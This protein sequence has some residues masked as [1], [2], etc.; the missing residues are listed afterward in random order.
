MKEFLVKSGKFWEAG[1][2]GRRGML[3]GHQAAATGAGATNVKVVTT[4]QPKPRTPG[5]QYGPTRAQSP[6]GR[7]IT[8]RTA[9]PKAPYAPPQARPLS[10]A[11]RRTLLPGQPGAVPGAYAPNVAVRPR[12]AGSRPRIGA[13]VT[14][15]APV[16]QP[17][18]SA[19]QVAARAKYGY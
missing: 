1:G 4:M 18:L 5:V 9:R 2:S 12:W 15:R 19:A 11:A 13:V 6:S 16:A 3:A 10:A 17:Q 7:V 8:R 14:R